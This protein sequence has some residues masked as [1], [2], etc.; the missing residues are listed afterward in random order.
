MNAISVEASGLV[1]CSDSQS[2]RMEISFPLEGTPQTV[3]VEVLQVLGGVAIDSTRMFME[4]GIVNTKDGSMS[5]YTH[6]CGLGLPGSAGEA[7]QLLAARPD[8]QH[9]ASQGDCVGGFMNVRPR[10]HELTSL[11]IA[12]FAAT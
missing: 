6:P 3:S 4:V 11:D 7:W 2:G 1:V 10:L 5:M 12:L 8:V 9:Y